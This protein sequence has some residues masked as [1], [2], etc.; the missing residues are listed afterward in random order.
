MNTKLAALWAV[1]TAASAGLVLCATVVARADGPMPDP[2][3]PAEAVARMHLAAA[4]RDPDCRCAVLH[5]RDIESR[6]DGHVERFEQQTHVERTAGRQARA[7]V[8]RHRVRRGRH[9]LSRTTVPAD[10][11]RQRRRRRHAVTNTEG[12]KAKSPAEA[13]LF[14]WAFVAPAKAG[15][16]CL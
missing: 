14:C 6:I 2:P 12:R 13:G 16:Q 15:A 10:D 11:G 8:A 1:R 7:R 3:V 9:R 5:A 4:E